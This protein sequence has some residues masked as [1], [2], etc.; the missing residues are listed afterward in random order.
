MLLFGL[1]PAVT[2][3]PSYGGCNIFPANMFWNVKVDTL[4]VHPSAASFATVM[5]STRLHLDLG[6]ETNQNSDVY[7]GIPWNLAPAGTPW[8][9]I[10]FDPA[11]NY[12]DESDCATGSAAPYTINSPCGTTSALTG[13]KLPIPTNANVESG[14]VATSD[15][16]DHHLLLVDAA[17]CSL[18]EVYQTYKDTNGW[19]CPGGI[20]RWDLRSG[21]LRPD[22]WTSS[23]A[24]GLPVM[25][26]LIRQDEA[27]A[28]VIKH[29]FRFTLTKA[30]IRGP[31][32]VYEWPARHN[33]GS[34][35]ANTPMMGQ[36]FRL[37]ASFTI[38]AAWSA[39]S[40]A[41]ATAFKEYGIIL[42]DIGS[43]M[44][45]QGEPSASWDLDNMLSQLQ[46]ITAADFEAVDISGW[47][48]AAGFNINSGLVPGVS[49]APTGAPNAVSTAKPTSAPTGKPTAAPTTVP[50]TSGTTV[51]PTSP[52]TAGSSAAPTTATASTGAPTDAG[53]TNSGA[54]LTPLLALV[55]LMFL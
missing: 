7:Y 36:R 15:G 30:N 31:S 9:P 5:G 38:P 12:H 2:A 44:F 34:G 47:K 4:P 55:A 50:T 14:I 6:T 48:S 16:A 53:T 24:A 39:Q 20:A 41:I 11:G 27:A 28:G 1:L 23:D 26:L 49:A 29:A 18:W 40:K 22:R 21:A 3:Q 17:N 43:N 51:A 33:T 8:V 10:T 37:K 45:L 42:A 52:T 46:S 54:A 25:P 13:V 35:G 19:L 32:S